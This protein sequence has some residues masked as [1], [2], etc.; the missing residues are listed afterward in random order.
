[1]IVQP[2]RKLGVTVYVCRRPNGSLQF[3]CKACRK[4]FPIMSG[5]LFAFHKMPLCT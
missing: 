5:T 2:G 1:V 4:D 3:R